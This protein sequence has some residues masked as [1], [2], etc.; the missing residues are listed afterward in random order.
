MWRGIKS[1]QKPTRVEDDGESLLA[2][3]YCY[4][5]N[6]SYCFVFLSP[7]QKEIQIQMFLVLSRALPNEKDVALRQREKKKHLR[8]LL[9]QV[10][11]NFLPRVDF[12]FR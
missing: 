9:F 2:Y 1:N 8:I 11:E 4:S 6:I 5:S 7:S 10:S 12:Y 3:Y